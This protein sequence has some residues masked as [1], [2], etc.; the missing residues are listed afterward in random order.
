M[1]ATLLPLMLLYVHRRWNGGHSSSSNVAL[2]SQALEWRSFFFL[3]CRFTSTGA[4]MAAILLRPLM[5]LYI[6]RRWNGGHT[7]SSNVGLRPQSK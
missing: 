3:E 1:A 5:S 4:G 6:H 7:S 2:R